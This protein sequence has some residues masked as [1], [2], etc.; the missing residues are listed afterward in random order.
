LTEPTSYD[1]FGNATNNLSTRYQFT[2]R[3]FDNFTGLHYYRA[4]WYDGNLGRFI[5]EDPIGFGGGDINLY[6]YV[7]NNS[8][9]HRDPS[10]KQILPAEEELLEVLTEEEI[11]ELREEYREAFGEPFGFGAGY[12]PVVQRMVWNTNERMLERWGLPCSL[13]PD[14][15]PSMGPAGT[16]LNTNSARGNYGIYE[17]TIDEE[18]YK[19]GKADLNRVTKSTNQPTRL[20][21]QVRKLQ[22]LNPDSNVF[23]RV[24]RELPNST[25]RQAKAVESSIIQDY[26]D[27]NAYVPR[28]N[29]RSFKPR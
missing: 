26:F 1:S 12:D 24:I 8:I 25:T 7:R 21:Q 2:G 18:T 4:R 3:E 6:G 22:E 5:S 17:I 9:R 20:H 13:A 15:E 11:E 28:G 14:S 29:S 10:G 16:N 23:G 19:F 27:R